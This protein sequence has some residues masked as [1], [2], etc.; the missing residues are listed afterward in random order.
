LAGALQQLR[1]EG[2]AKVVGYL[3]AVLVEVAFETKLN[4]S[5]VTYRTERD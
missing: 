5:V 3:E 4:P 2:Q 1:L